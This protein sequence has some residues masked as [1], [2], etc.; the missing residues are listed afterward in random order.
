MVMKR[1]PRGI[2]L[3]AWEQQAPQGRAAGTRDRQYLTSCLDSDTQQLG[4]GAGGIK[5]PLQPPRE[6]D[7]GPFPVSL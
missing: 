1:G 4:L 2:R 5:E 3:G 7:T 6:S